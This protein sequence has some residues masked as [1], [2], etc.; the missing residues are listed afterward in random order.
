MQK[1]IES[2]VLRYFIGDVRDAERQRRALASIEMGKPQPVDT[3][4]DAAARWVHR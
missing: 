2:P 4:E 1:A 3:I